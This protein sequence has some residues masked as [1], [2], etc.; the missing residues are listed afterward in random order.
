[1]LHL[2]RNSRIVRVHSTRSYMVILHGSRKYL[3]HFKC[4]FPRRLTIEVYKDCLIVSL[5]LHVCT[6]SISL[7]TRMYSSTLYMIYNTYRTNLY[8][9]FKED[10]RQI[11]RCEE[12]LVRVYDLHD[13]NWQHVCTNKRLKLIQQLNKRVMMAL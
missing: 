4:P 5:V 1:M 6:L 10:D 12:K 11:V 3:C 2:S 8:Y 13:T 9:T 7:Y